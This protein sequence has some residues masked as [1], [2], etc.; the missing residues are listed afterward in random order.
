MEQSEETK[1]RMREY[2]KKWY[3]ENKEKVKEKKRLYNIKNKDKI[4]ERRRRNKDKINERRKKNRFKNR[5]KINKRN[6]EKYKENKQQLK[7]YTENKERVK[8]VQRQYR[9]KNKEKIKEYRGTLKYKEKK[10]K[11]IK[12][13]LKT[14]N[15]FR[16]VSNLRTRLR[17]AIKDQNTEKAFKF[18]ELLGCTAKEAREHIENQFKKGMTWE[19][20]GVLGWHIDHIIPCSYFDLTDPEQQ[21][22]CFNY[23]NLQPL[24]AHENLSKSVKI[25]ENLKEEKNQ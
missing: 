19:N 12:E 7:Y 18:I 3:L 25:P 15:E 5:D 21:K 8:E 9:L 14:N 23:T 13:K 24:W 2:S 10:K 11:Y 4:N 20:Y 1:E 22:K 6:R 16:I 17:E